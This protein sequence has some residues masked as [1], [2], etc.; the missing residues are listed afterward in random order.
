MTPFSKLFFALAVLLALGMA[1]S[2]VKAAPSQCDVVV[3]NLVANC[4]FE[5]GTFAGWTQTGNTGFTGVSGGIFAHTGNFG[6]A[7]G[8]VFIPGGISQN[9]VTVPGGL[10]TVSFFL[11]NLGGFNGNNPNQFSASFGGT[12][13]VTQTNAAAFGYTQFTFSNLIATGAL[14]QLAFQFR[15][16]ASFFLLDDVVVTSQATTA[17]PE[18]ASMLLLGTGLAGAVGAI[19]RRRKA[20]I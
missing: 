8:P 15:N 19:C 16:D 11:A 13:F 1:P 7:F 6:A 14:T 2:A 4:G 3:G 18:P 12:Q 5:T 10:Y 9:L 20:Q 17:T